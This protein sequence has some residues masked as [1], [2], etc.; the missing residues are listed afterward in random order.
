M[1]T[2]LLEPTTT[3]VLPLPEKAAEPTPLDVGDWVW[4]LYWR[5]FPM[6]GNAANGTWETS[7][8]RVVSIGRSGTVCHEVGNFST[9]TDDAG[10]PE[11]YLRF[12]PADRVFRTPE[13]ANEARASRPAPKS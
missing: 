5:S 3:E 9:A 8:T 1:P 7:P 2:E 10:N 4:V 6:S 12:T 11:S 13:E